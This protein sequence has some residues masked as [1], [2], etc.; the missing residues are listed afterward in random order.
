MASVQN[1]DNDRVLYSIS[2]VQAITG[3]GTP[4]IRKWEAAFRDYLNV[5]RTRG[6]QRRFNQEAVDKIEMLKQLIYEEGLSL[7]GARKRLEQMDS[8]EMVMQEGDPTFE[9]LADMVTDMLLQKLFREGL[10]PPRDLDPPRRS[11]GGA[12]SD[13][14]T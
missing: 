8:P 3:V 10:S 7:E 4:T 13:P 11:R 1:H 9:K 2:Q 12:G 6:G 5:V 14:G